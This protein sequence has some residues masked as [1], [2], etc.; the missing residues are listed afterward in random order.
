[1]NDDI[2]ET[3]LREFILSKRTSFSRK[4]CQGRRRALRISYTDTRNDYADGRAPEPEG[5]SLDKPSG[6]TIQLKSERHRRQKPI[7]KRPH[8]QK[9]TVQRHETNKRN[10]SYQ[11]TLI[12]SPG[13][14]ANNSENPRHPERKSESHNKMLCGYAIFPN[15]APSSAGHDR[16]TLNNLFA[17]KCKT[18]QMK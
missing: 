8:R 5:F 6:K 15:S 13:G 2:Y 7:R 10:S 3:S 17:N 16:R 11:A 4:V 1:M 14:S 12:K 9:E 18:V